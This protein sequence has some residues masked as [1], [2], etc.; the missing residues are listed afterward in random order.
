MADS[1]RVAA[2]KRMD[3]FELRAK[4]CA[5]HLAAQALESDQYQA[6]YKLLV[7][8]LD[9]LPAA[10]RDEVIGIISDALD[11]AFGRKEIHDKYAK[12]QRRGYGTYYLERRF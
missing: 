9:K 7:D 3:E 10:E 1:A 4:V 8:D 11:K 2:A 5:A 12:V 6:T